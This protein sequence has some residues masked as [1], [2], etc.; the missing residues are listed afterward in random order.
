MHHDIS[1]PGVSAAD[2]GGPQLAN[3]GQ[4]FQ[5]QKSVKSRAFGPSYGDRPLGAEM[6]NMWRGD[7]PTHPHLHK[8]AG[9]RPVLPHEREMKSLDRFK[10]SSLGPLTPLDKH[11]KG[12]S[13]ALLPAPRGDGYG[14][15]VLERLSEPGVRQQLPLVRDHGRRPD[16]SQVQSARDYDSSIPQNQRGPNCGPTRDLSGVLGIDRQE[17]LGSEAQRNQGLVPQP[18]VGKDGKHL[19]IS[20]P[21]GER[22]YQRPLSQA[23][24]GRG[25]LYSLLHGQGSRHYASPGAEGQGGKDLGHVAKDKSGPRI[26][27]TVSVDPSHASLNLQGGSYGPVIAGGTPSLGIASVE[28]HGAKSFTADGQKVKHLG[29]P[30][31]DAT[32]SKAGRNDPATSYIGGPGNYLGA[33]LGAGGYGPGNVGR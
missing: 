21:R 16:P 6:P 7:V 15:T 30:E 8:E 19:G 14:P 3:L 28:K 27:G 2:L 26:H 25:H 9:F 11:S 1:L 29:Q 5:D 17:H 4:A 31:R 12:L 32:E 22:T 33:N 13:L 20:T 18:H 24:D 10:S 23:Q